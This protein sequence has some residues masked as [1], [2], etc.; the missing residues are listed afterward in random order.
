MYRLILAI[1]ALAILSIPTSLH[2]GVSY[3]FLTQNLAKTVILVGVLAAS[4]RDRRDVDRLVRMLVLG[5]AGYVTAGLVLAVPEMGR[6]AGTGGM[7]SYDPNDLGLVTVATIPMCIY[8]M[9]R[10]AP[11]GDRILGM[12]SAALLLVAAV[13]TGSRGGFLA[14]AAVALYGLLGLRAV[15]LSRRL[16]VLFVASAAIALVGG[17]AYRDRIGTLLAPHEDY[18]W[19]GHAESGRMEIWRRGLG[20]IAQRP[21]LGVGLNAFFIAEGNSPEAAR[22]RAQGAGFK[23]SAAHNSYIQIGAELGVFGLVSFIALLGLAVREA[24]R[25]GNMAARGEDRLLAQCFGALLVG[26]AVGAAFLSQAY[27]T[28]LY[29]SLGILIGFSRVMSRERDQ[30]RTA[31]PP[32][33]ARVGTRHRAVIGPREVGPVQV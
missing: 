25:I 31:S 26:F 6:L 30:P 9:R 10:G 8:M 4:I 13:K 20:Y 11:G 17:A 22:R 5:G 29:F 2:T 24:R 21:L 32:R 16:T 28:F 23:W 12:V 7:G 15:R 18:N 19:S 3:D 14:L 1:F 33:S 27:A